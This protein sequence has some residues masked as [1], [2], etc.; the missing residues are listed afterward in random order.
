MT[1]FIKVQNIEEN[2][3]DRNYPQISEILL[4]LIL[5]STMQKAQVFKILPLNVFLMS[6]QQI[7]ESY[8]NLNNP[9]IETFIVYVFRL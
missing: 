6:F 4:M 3:L 1:L 5:Y 2:I 8:K 9:F 7:Y